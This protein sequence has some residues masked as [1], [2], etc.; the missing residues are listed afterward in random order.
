MRPS[1]SKD[2]GNSPILIALKDGMGNQLNFRE[3]SHGVRNI[4]NHWVLPHGDRGIK[5]AGSQLLARD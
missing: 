3:E 2:S 1:T 4:K 5:S